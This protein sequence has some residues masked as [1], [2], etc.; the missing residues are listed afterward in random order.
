MPPG[1]PVLLDRTT[2]QPRKIPILAPPSISPPEPHGA[3]LVLHPGYGAASNVIFSLPCVDRYERPRVDSSDSRRPTVAAP[4]ASSA[5]TASTAGFGVHHRTA[6]VAA[7]IVANNAVDGFLAHDRQG[8]QRVSEALEDVLTDRK[9]FFIVP[10]D[11]MS[12]HSVATTLRVAE[13]SSLPIRSL[14]HR[15]LLPGLALPA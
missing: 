13:L 6:L 7:Q 12:F 3:L 2:G 14:P 1:I 5:T 15:S 8:T 10:G 4:T 11:G 9:Y